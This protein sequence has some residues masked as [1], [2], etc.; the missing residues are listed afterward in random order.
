MDWSP[1]LEDGETVRWQGRPAPRCYTFRNWKHSLFGLAL[2]LMS[3]LWLSLGLH[4]A[5]GKLWGWLPLPFALGGLY[6]SGG[7]LLW[8]R[9]QWEG[10]FYAVTDRRVIVRKSLPQSVLD[11]PLAEIAFFQVRPFGDNLG[12]IRITVEGRDAPLVMPCIEYPET[13]AA[14]LRRVVEP[15]GAD[16][17]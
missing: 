3:L 8:S 12:T 9:L 1:Y 13:P 6:L 7:H 4:L 16:S 11:C 15:R 14:L 10:V 2:L 5:P 17:V